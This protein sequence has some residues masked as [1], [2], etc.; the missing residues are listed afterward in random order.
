MAESWNGRE[1]TWVRVLAFVP[2]LLRDLNQVLLLR[3]GAIQPGDLWYS[4]TSQTALTLF[5]KLLTLWPGRPVFL[6][7]A[8]IT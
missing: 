1:E 3:N 2:I 6:Y 5:Q 8:N 4:V 7:K